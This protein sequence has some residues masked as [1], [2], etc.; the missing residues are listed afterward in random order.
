LILALLILS[1]WSNFLILQLRAT[2]MMII[3]MMR[4]P[5]SPENRYSLVFSY[6]L[7]LAM[8]S[9]LRM[10]L[11]SDALKL[12]LGN[13]PEL[14]MMKRMVP[15]IGPTPAEGVMLKLTDVSLQLKKVELVEKTLSAANSIDL[16]HE[17]R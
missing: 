16:P 14:S 10:R 3:I 1:S 8:T 15:V 12:A 7:T 11:I 6:S 4:M 13:R 2:A 5:V 9:L 17:P